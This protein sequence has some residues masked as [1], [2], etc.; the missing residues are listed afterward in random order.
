[1][2]PALVEL[3]EEGSSDDEVSVILRLA[4]EGVAPPD[5]RVVAQFGRPR[6]KIVTARCLRG[7]IPRIHDSV[8]VV[9]MKASRHMTLERAYSE[10]VTYGDDESDVDLLSPEGEVAET[11]AGVVVGICDWGFDFTHPNFRNADGS[12]RL[13]ALW[14]Q[15][16]EGGDTPQPYG[17]GR[18][19][20]RDDINRALV[21]RDPRR[22]LGYDPSRG[23]PRGMGTHGTHVLDILAGNR[24]EPGSRVGLARDADIV[25]VD[26]S[27]ESLSVLSNFGDSV[28]LLEGV[29]F[30]RNQAGAK[31][32]KLWTL[33]QGE[34]L[35]FLRIQAGAKPLVMH[36]SA[37]K[38]GGTHDWTGC[39]ERAIDAMLLEQPGVVLVQ[40]AGNYGDSR[41]HTHGWV[42]PGRRHVLHWLVSS[43]DRT[44]NE[45]EIWYSGNDQF[46][47]TLVAPDGEA[48]RAELG[49]NVKLFR[50]GVRW[51]TLYHRKSEP[52]SGLNHIVIFLR[53]GSL[54]GNYRVELQ[55]IDI[56]DGRFNAWIERDA[57]GV[58]QSHFPRWQ[59]TRQYTTNTIC[60]S[61]YGIAVGA[62]DPSVSARPPAPFTS[63]G[64][65]SDGRQK[66]EL[67]APGLRILAARSEPAQGWR[68]ERRLTIKS[69]TSMAAPWV[70]GTV[71]LMMQAARR[72]LTIHEIRRLLIGSVDPEGAFPGRMQPLLGFGYLN[73]ARAV[74]AARRF[75]AKTDSEEVGDEETPPE[76]PLFVVDRKS[77]EP[78]SLAHE[79]LSEEAIDEGS[80][81]SIAAGASCG[82]QQDHRN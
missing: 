71:A 76:W 16:G 2:D 11:G 62:F 25:C 37:G 7:N 64:P 47:A 12:T 20:T 24:R 53:T 82:C 46:A 56:V 63:Q 19:H 38:T 35:D 21:S 15:S 44:P 59:A 8:E 9:S 70:S 3:Y 69:G 58:H 42:A 45:L 30:L 39:F 4:A 36:L 26:L 10:E 75:G 81:A 22:A 66:P 41:M 52:N 55:G 14:D 57:A 51:G 43:R 5:V 77:L 80:S 17:Y 65:T 18:L 67:A 72:P 29:D 31:P 60:N 23:D 13:L 61:Y 6:P 49:Q 48:F 33:E 40:S 79:A 27:I 78:P 54:P 34:Q 28:R 74:E 32:S 1:M 68:G 50:S 73:T